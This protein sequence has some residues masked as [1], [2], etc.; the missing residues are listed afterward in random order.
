MS[1]VDDSL[2]DSAEKLQV[3]FVDHLFELVRAESVFLSPHDLY[4][5]QS[6]NSEFARGAGINNAKRHTIRRNRVCTL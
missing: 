2:E 6:K 4:T 3:G 5:T 1:R